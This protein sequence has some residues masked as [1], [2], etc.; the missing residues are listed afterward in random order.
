MTEKEFHRNA[1]I[2][3]VVVL[4]GLL[5]WFW[6]HSQAQ[7]ADQTL[8]AET[9]TPAGT[10]GFGVQ[11]YSSPGLGPFNFPVSVI[12]PTNN[13]P[14]T[15]N[16]GNCMCGCD[17]NGVTI[18][19][20][21]VPGLQDM[22]DNLAATAQA[23]QQAALSSLYS[24]MGAPEAVFVSNANTTTFSGGNPFDSYASYAHT[25]N[26]GNQPTAWWEQ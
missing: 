4:I 9:V 24:S 19:N 22:L 14:G 13:P 12:Q 5:L 8:P 23:A 21:N 10:P 7:A 25:S 11:G 17:G 18:V 2:V 1:L 15:L 20:N 26:F 6:A 3:G 16:A